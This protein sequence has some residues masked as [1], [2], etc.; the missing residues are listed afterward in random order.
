MLWKFLHGIDHTSNPQRHPYILNSGANYNYLLNHQENSPSLLE[1]LVFFIFYS[2]LI[3]FIKTSFAKPP[4]DIKNYLA[5]DELTS[6]V[7]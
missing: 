3:R 6:L 4:L 1:P 2:S 7:K 5:Y